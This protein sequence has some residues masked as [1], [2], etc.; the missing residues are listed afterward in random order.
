MAIT[1]ADVNKLRQQTGAGMMDCK[2]ALEETGGNFEEAV[3]YLRKKG[4]K[5]SDKRADKE[6]KEGVCLAIT[7]DDNKRGVTIRLACETDF[8]AKGDDFVNFAKAIAEKAL[9]EKPSDEAALLAIKHGDLTINEHIDE[10]CGK[11][12][13]KIQLNAYEQLEGEFVSAYVHANYKIGVIAQATK[14][15]ND[16]S[17][18]KDVCMQIA[19]M[20]PVAVDEKSVDPTVIARELEIAKEQ[21]AAEGKPADMIEKI[22]QGKLQRFYKDSTLLHQAFVKDGSKSVKD[23]LVADDKDLS[24]VAFRRVQLGA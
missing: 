23:V 4:A 6:S 19:A 12:G 5:V 18:V 16:P 15:P 3:V 21:L 14:K 1:A 22:A 20:N 17:I 7:S 9:T 11:I 8:V 24:I 13:E 10:M 2:K